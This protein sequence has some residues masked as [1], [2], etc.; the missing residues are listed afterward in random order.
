MTLA[1]LADWLADSGLRNLPLEEMV[2]GF[3]RRLNDMG[4]PV[5]RTFVGMNTLHPMVRARS[6][7]WD[8]A[9]GP[10]THFEFRHADIDAPIV[11]ESPFV[12]MLRDGIAER[13]R[14]VDDPAVAREAPVFEE[15]HAAGMTEWLGRVFPMG[16]L[17]PQDRRSARG[18][19][20]RAA[21]ARL[22]GHDRPAGRL[23]RLRPGG[24]EA[25][26]AA[27]RAGRQG[28]HHAHDR[29]WA[30][31][32]LSRQRSGEPR[33]R[34]HGAARRGAERR[35]HRCS[36]PTCAASPRWPISRPARN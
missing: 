5:A 33:L 2:D 35:R 1:A 8:R 6:M 20:C 36:S 7:I 29:P 4:V 21:G 28:R 27:V 31:G 12:P 17:V 11:R 10:G 15:L 3:S 24:A 25:G 13:R 32:R 18:R 30:A 14:R 23:S 26:A 22:L 9:T 16:E 19:A 34:R